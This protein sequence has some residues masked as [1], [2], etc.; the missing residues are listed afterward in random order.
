MPKVVE[1]IQ[2]IPK[3]QNSQN[4]QN[5]QNAGDSL[6]KYIPQT[7]LDQYST[8]PLFLQL[9]DIPIKRF[10]YEKAAE[11]IGNFIKANAKEND[12]S[13]LED[14][15]EK[16][17]I[18]CFHRVMR[19]PK[20]VFVQELGKEQIS[21]HVNPLLDIFLSQFS[22][23]LRLNSKAKERECNFN[24]AFRLF[25]RM[26]AI[27][28][29]LT[30][31]NVPLPLTAAQEASPRDVKR[32]FKNLEKRA[33]EKLGSAAPSELP[34]LKYNES[35]GLLANGKMASG[36]FMDSRRLEAR[37]SQKKLSPALAWKDTQT[38]MSLFENTLKRYLRELEKPCREGSQRRIS[39]KL[40]IKDI[41]GRRGCGQFSPQLT[42][43][44]LQYL[45]CVYSPLVIRSVMDNSAGWGDRFTAFMACP[46]IEWI[47]VNDIADLQPIYQR[48]RQFFK[49]QKNIAYLRKP[50]ED[51]QPE[52]LPWRNGG[53]MRFD[54]LISS[55]PT[56]QECYGDFE[57]QACQVYK[58]PRE[59][60]DKFLV[61]LVHC[62]QVVLKASGVVA[63]EIKGN[64]SS[65]K[66]KEFKYDYSGELY[67]CFTQNPSL[68]S[69]ARMTLIEYTGFSKGR[70]GTEGT[71]LVSAQYTPVMPA[72]LLDRLPIPEPSSNS[73]SEGV[74]R[75]RD[76]FNEHQGNMP[77]QPRY[78]EKAEELV[79]KPDEQFRR[80]ILIKFGL[81]KPDLDCDQPVCPKALAPAS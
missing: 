76:G 12:K 42:I 47:M 49:S 39:N 80:R 52:D 72:Q 73:Y 51:I 32:S 68:F 71:Y 25:C 59:Y 35:L 33:A 79:I 62:A 46:Q 4:S 74:K 61:R 3:G 53:P 7:E 69:N 9:M 15:V 41:I 67:K 31:Q 38:K 23:A 27:K 20:N 17:I 21:I 22:D 29:V 43:D 45:Q 28:A 13:S 78:P 19:L 30:C 18:E 77:K 48:M 6:R 64:G 11:L 75:K 1:F 8:D 5:S 81:F 70:Y 2:Y 60:I 54:A 58:T 34:Q 65:V 14:A 16:R 56:T 66:H 57:G 10:Q 26:L 50:L 44:I 63:Y 55:P 24:E 40:L 36:Y 37:Y